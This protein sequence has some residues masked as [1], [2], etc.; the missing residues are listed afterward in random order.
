[1]AKLTPRTDNFIA[2]LLMVSARARVGDL[3]SIPENER[4]ELL[5]A[6]A[7][8][9]A[10]EANF[11]FDGETLSYV[12]APA[13]SVEPSPAWHDQAP[14]SAP[15]PAPEWPS[16]PAAPV[17][18][19]P[20]PVPA[21]PMPA[22][23]EPTPIP[24]EPTPIPAESM[25]APFDLASMPAPTGIPAA[26]PVDFAPLP[27]APMEPMSVA[28][29]PVEPAPIADWPVPAPAPQPLEP[30]PAEPVWSMPEPAVPAEPPQEWAAPSLDSIPEVFPA[31]QELDFE[32]PQRVPD[33]VPADPEYAS[34]TGAAT[35][36][37]IPNEELPA[38][39]FENTEADT[40]L[41]PAH[42]SLA[43]EIAASP[44][45]QFVPNPEPLFVPAQPDLDE[46]EPLFVPAQ[47]DLEEAEPQFAPSSEPAIETVPEI[48][49]PELPDLP[50]EAGFFLPEEE[51]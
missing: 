13:P 46:S 18:A 41:D 15:A 26:I 43:E 8:V 12:M 38:W 11:T 37:E 34:D 20:M 14:P 48:E 17:P 31:G 33:A 28:P 7:S 30:I 10:A 24:A 51:G 9:H 49:L 22:P 42:Q 27:S 32:I 25:P 19:G 6:Y 5:Q 45:P 29:A 35:L 21:E 4:A 47:P 50:P 39:F 3:S 2:T 44:E 16:P 1:M 23:V 40:P 36:G